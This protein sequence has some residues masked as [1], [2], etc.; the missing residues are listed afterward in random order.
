MK[1]L[2]WWIVAIVSSAGVL[3]GVAQL[4]PSLTA[5]SRAATTINWPLHNLDLAGTRFSTMDQINR[6]NVKTLSPRWLFQHGVIDGVSNQ[7]TPIVVDGTM[8]VTDSRGSVYAL[9][10]GDGHLLWTYDV[11]DLIGG[12]AREGY[13]FRN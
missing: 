12:G 3:A 2:Q 1:R 7:T 9:D 13:V 5:Q 4:V 8:Y 11:T 10:A 6:S